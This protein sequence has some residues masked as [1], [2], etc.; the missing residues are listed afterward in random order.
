MKLKGMAYVQR[1]VEVEAPNVDAAIEWA[2]H[3]VAED[4]D[5]LWTIVEMQEGS[6]QVIGGSCHAVY[7][8]R[9]GSR[10]RPKQ[11]ERK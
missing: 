7:K 8:S 3:D 6:I 9:A 2:V 5:G 4:D 1:E 11:R 10:A